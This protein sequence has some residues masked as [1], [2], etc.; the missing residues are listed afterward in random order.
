MAFTGLAEVWASSRCGLSLIPW[1]CSFSGPKQCGSSVKHTSDGLKRP[2]LA[3]TICVV[4]IKS[5]NISE[6]V[7]P[8]GIHR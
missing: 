6:F 4:L 2:D 7:F 1:L 3:L 5:L 8:T